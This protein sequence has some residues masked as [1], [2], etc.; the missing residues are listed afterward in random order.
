[1]ELWVP[2]GAD[3]DSG[4]TSSRSLPWRPSRTYDAS[5]NGDGAGHH[6]VKELERNYTMANER[7][8][9]EAAV[10]ALTAPGAVPEFQLVECLLEGVA[11]RSEE[12]TSELLSLRHL[13]C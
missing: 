4:S 6:K 9:H 8:V 3:I 13:V 10:G 7:L 2:S 5:S 12:H 11:E 1:M